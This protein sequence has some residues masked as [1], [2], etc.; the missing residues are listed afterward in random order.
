MATDYRALH[1]QY[2]QGMSQSGT[3]QPNQ[4]PGFDFLQG[5]QTKPHTGYLP[6]QQARQQPLQYGKP[7]T[8]GWIGGPDGQPVGGQDPRAMQYDGIP[9]NWAAWRQAQS[10]GAGDPRGMQSDGIGSNF[11]DWAAAYQ[12]PQGGQSGA[13]NPFSQQGNMQANFG[14][15]Q[16]QPMPKPQP[17]F[18]T[19]MPKPQPNFGTPM[20]KPMPN[21]GDPM[22]K[23]IPGF[24]VQPTQPVQY[25]Q[26]GKPI[27]LDQTN[28]GR[29]PNLPPMGSGWGG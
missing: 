10:T 24:G 11:R 12:R 25:D 1:G 13:S 22:P 6:P 21:F 18:G 16:P 3:I 5:W 7:T 23:P 26:Y 27:P 17:N 14:M 28:P 9:G 20:P 4:Q 29:N 15:Q 19:P 2:S 8:G